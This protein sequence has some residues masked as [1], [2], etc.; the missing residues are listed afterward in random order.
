MST[1]L[2]CALEMG[3]QCAIV[4]VAVALRRVCDNDEEKKGQ[5]RDNLNLFMYQ[6][7]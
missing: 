7:M 4:V 2:D 3:S 6:N 1:C 5:T